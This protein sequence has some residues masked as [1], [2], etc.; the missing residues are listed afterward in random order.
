MNREFH[1]F[2]LIIVS[3][4]ELFIQELGLEDAKVSK[5][6]HGHRGVM[7]WTG[8]G[9]DHHGFVNGDNI[10]EIFYP[11]GDD[12]DDKKNFEVGFRLWE[13]A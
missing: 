9:D 4:F 8:K 13:I 12:A 11:E 2:Q 6:A 10:K 5:G 1:A 3:T 7:Q